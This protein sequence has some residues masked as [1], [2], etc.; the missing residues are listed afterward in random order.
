MPCLRTRQGALYLQTPP[1]LSDSIFRSRPQ[2][3]WEISLRLC[4]RRPQECKSN[5]DCQSNQCLGRVCA[6]GATCNNG[7]KD[8]D[9]SDVDC[10][11]ISSGCLPCCWGECAASSSAG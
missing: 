10:G 6:F 5:K 2:P 3:A 11:G 7:I 4:A 9:E 1:L 8:A